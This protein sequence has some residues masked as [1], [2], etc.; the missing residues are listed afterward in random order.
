MELTLTPEAEAV[1]ARELQTGRYASPSELIENALHALAD[2]KTLDLSAF[3]QKVQQ[4]LDDVQR[5]DVFTEAEARAY[6][7]AARAKL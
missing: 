4:G 3:N 2:S 6:L 5:G 7:K 1:L